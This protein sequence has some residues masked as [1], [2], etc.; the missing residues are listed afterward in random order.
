[1][2]NL[3]MNLDLGLERVPSML[4]MKT[5]GKGILIILVI[6]PAS[7]KNTHFVGDLHTMEVFANLGILENLWE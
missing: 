7:G 5:V 4:Y 1:M 3:A 6:A 2:L